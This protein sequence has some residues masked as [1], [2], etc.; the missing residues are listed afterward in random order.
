[1]PRLGNARPPLS[2]VTANDWKN[3]AEFAHLRVAES[4][5]AYSYASRLWHWARILSTASVISFDI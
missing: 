5:F 3:A 1:M 4:H 2:A